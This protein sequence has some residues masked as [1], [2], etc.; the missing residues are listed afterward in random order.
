MRVEITN[1][2]QSLEVV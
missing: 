2:F 1:S